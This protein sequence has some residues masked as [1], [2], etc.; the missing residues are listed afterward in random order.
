[1][2][3]YLLVRHLSPPYCPASPGKTTQLPQYLHEAGYSKLGRIG[4]TQPRRVAAMSVAARVAHEMGVKLGN[5]VGYLIR[6]EDCTSPM[7]APFHC[8]CPLPSLPPPP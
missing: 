3:Y 5:E 6:F 2:A 8:R 1:M 7:R 4:C